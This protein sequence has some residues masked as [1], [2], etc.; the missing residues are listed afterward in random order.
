MQIIFVPGESWE[1]LRTKTISHILAIDDQG[2]TEKTL[3]ALDDWYGGDKKYEAFAEKYR[4]NGELLQQKDKI[5]AMRSWSEFE[6][7]RYT[8]TIFVNGLELPSS[9][10]PEDLIYTLT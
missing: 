2:D 5:A 9:Y 3:R 10:L 1:D 6:G 7:I 4:L 8:P